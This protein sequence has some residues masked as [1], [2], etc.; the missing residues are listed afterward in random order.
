MQCEFCDY[1]CA[2][3]TQLATHKF[4]KHKI[5]NQVADYVDGTLCKACLT[6]CH[7]RYK[8]LKHI[9][10]T[11]KSCR[12][13][14]LNHVRICDPEVISTLT[15]EENLRVKAAKKLGYG[16]KYYPIPIYKVFGPVPH[17]S[18]YL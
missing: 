11:Y 6:Q 7:T 17:N 10:Y 14:Y 13:Y 8:L 2:T 3:S 18:Y 16:P 15:F 4:A 12:H 5:K 9:S 1:K